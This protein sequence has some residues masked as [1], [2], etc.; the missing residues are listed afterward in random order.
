VAEHASDISGD[1]VETI[2]VGSDVVTVIIGDIIGDGVRE[3]SG[4]VLSFASA[5]VLCLVCK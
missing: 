3:E 5:P 1:P 4:P 2:G